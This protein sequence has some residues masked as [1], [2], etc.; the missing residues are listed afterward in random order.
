VLPRG[1]PG[2]VR[3]AVAAC[4]A[5]LAPEGTGLLLAPSHR[6]MSDIP[7]ANVEALLAAFAESR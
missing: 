6:L 1:A 5:A 2:E 7:M 3:A 4:R